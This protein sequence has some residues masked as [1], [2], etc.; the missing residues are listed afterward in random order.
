MFVSG[1]V[2]L[3]YPEYVYEAWHGTCLTIAVAIL[4]LLFNIFLARKLPLLEGCLVVIHILGFFATLVTLWVLSPT[5]EPKTVFTKFGDS[6]GWGNLGGAAL[7][8]IT[9]AINPV[10]GADAA[11]HMSEEVKDA[12][13][14]VPRFVIFCIFVSDIH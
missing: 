8:G 2:V 1:L 9:S 11:V 7:I 14:S 5:G 10:L 6:G 12:G 4:A 3:N 13:R